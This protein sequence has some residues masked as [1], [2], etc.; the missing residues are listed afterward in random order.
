MAPNLMRR[1]R[2]TAQAGLCAM[3]LAAALGAGAAQAGSPAVTPVAGRPSLLL[4]AY[5][6]AALGYSTQE[7]FVSGT[8]TSYKLAGPPTPDGRWSASPADTAPYATRI[9]VLRPT[10]PAKFNGTVVVEWLNVT[11]GV[12]AS[13]DWNAAHREMIR[14]GYA[15][16]AVS[17]QK[18]GVEG[19]ASLGADM[20]LKKTRPDRYGKLSHPGDAYSY[21]IYSQAGRLVRSSGADGVLGGLVPKRILS[22]GESQSAV[23]LTTY[24]NAVDPLAKVYDGFLIHSR[25]GP[26]ARIDGGSI[27][28]AGPD[29]MLK[30]VRLRTDLRVPVMTFITETDLLG[31]RLAG[32]HGAQQPDNDHLRIWEVPGTSHADNYTVGGGFID[33]GSA[34]LAK[35]AAGYAP[36]TRFV[37]AQL[38]KPMNFAPQHHYVLQAALASLDAWVR[39]GEAPPKGARIKLT[40]ANPPDA[41][42]DAHGLAEGGI[43]TPWMDVPTARLSGVGNAGSPMASLVGVGE[44]FDATTLD[45]L[46]PGGKAEY[47]KQFDASLSKAIKAGFLLTAD[48][49]EILDLAGAMYPAAK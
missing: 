31:G 20:S 2:E 25:F 21:D 40:D 7:F 18:V 6:I 29:A 39:T 47:L 26:A 4:G 16:V 37:G 24:V 43:R 8:A 3:A 36:T 46:Y 27:I 15:Y 14:R 19:G 17:A 32:F 49:Q 34:P 35:L 28:G 48:R 41:V 38:A 10:D 30:G 23:F 22:V 5:D 9:V 1:V 13:P 33:S 42:R 45:K 11:A 12:D 44:P